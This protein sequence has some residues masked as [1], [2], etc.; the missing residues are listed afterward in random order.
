MQRNVQTFIDDVTAEKVTQASLTGTYDQLTAQVQPW[1]A[2]LVA[3]VK[4]DQLAQITL[5]TTHEPAISFRLETSVINLPLANLTEIGKVTVAD[6]TM[7]INVYM[8]AES[9]ALQSG[10]RIDELGSVDDVLADQ[11]N[12]EKLLTDWLS[13]QVDRLNQITAV[14]D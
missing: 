4:Q 13:A 10:L 7:P 5:T 2:K 1:L 3:A 6:D 11:A 14:E 12:A 9:E 8:I